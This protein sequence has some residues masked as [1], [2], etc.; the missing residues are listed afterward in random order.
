MIS[1]ELIFNMAKIPQ[2]SGESMSGEDCPP[3]ERGR[4]GAEYLLSTLGFSR[5]RRGKEKN[6]GGEEIS[7]LN[8]TQKS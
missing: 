5:E 7:T 3:E 6:G 8:R 4:G 2:S 1:P